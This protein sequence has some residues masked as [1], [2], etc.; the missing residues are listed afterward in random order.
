MNKVTGY[1]FKAIFSAFRATMVMVSLTAVYSSAATVYVSGDYNETTVGWGI[2]AFNTIQAGINAVEADG[3]VNVAAGTYEEIL[4]VN[5]AGVTV[6]AV[7]EAVVTFATVANDK[8]VITISADG[9]TFDGFEEQ[10]K[11]STRLS[12]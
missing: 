3:T 6:K 1:S 9:A 5:K 12:A 11:R 8:S 10:L 2:S 4:D 7:G